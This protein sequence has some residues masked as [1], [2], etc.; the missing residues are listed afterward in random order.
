MQCGVLL[1]LP[2]AD[3]LG[4]RKAGLVER[5]AE[6]DQA[7][8]RGFD[9]HREVGRGRTFEKKNDAIEF[10]FSGTAG[11]RKSQR[12]KQFPA[13]DFELG[14]KRIHDFIEAARGEGGGIEQLV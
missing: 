13:T 2:T 14:L 4:S 3:G 12:M 6:L 8:A 11:E 5:G 10:A 7:L 1:R 9:G